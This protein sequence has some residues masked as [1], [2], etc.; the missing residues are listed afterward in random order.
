M[1]EG[2]KELKTKVA[3]LEKQ[4]A[5]TSKKL[6]QSQQ[7]YSLLN[8]IIA[9]MPG[10]IYWMDKEGRILGCNDE[11]AQN[12][13]FS[14]NHDLIG[15]TIHDFQPKE[16]ADQI[17]K[18]NNQIIRAGKSTLVE[19]EGVL[20]NG[21]ETIFLSHKAPLKNQDGKVTG[22]IGIS[23]DITSN[24]YNEH[25]LENIISLLPGNIFWKSR[26]G[27]FL[28]CNNNVAKILKLQYPSDI[29]GKTNYDLFDAAMADQATEADNVVMQN[30]RE[31]VL[32]ETGLNDK[33]ELTEYLTRKV[34]LLDKNNNVVGLLGVSLDISDRKKIEQELKRAKERAEV[35]NKAKTEFILN[36]EHDLRTPSSG[37]YGL[38][39]ILADTA[40]NKNL[41]EQLKLIASASGELLDIL[42]DILRFHQIESGNLP[43][44][45]KK[46]NPQHLI[47]KIIRLESAAAKEKNIS[48]VCDCSR[49]I[50]VE[51]IGDEYRTH[52]ILL[53]L[54]SNAIK[55]TH[56]GG[57]S[58]LVKELKIIKP[59]T[60]IL[61][62]TIKDTGIGIPKEKSNMIYEKFSK[63]TLSNTGHYKGLGLG[64]HIVKQFV[65]EL[66]GDIE[67]T[68]E[69][70]KGSVFT[71]TLPFK[72]PLLD[73][74][75]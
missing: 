47:E 53:N 59:R 27:K 16:K 7:E 20:A 36:M 9:S 39:K 40:S 50:P 30:N 28:G 33:G 22:V 56:R 11:Q 41:K 3:T 4:L 44:L 75:Q 45:D 2:V 60:I 64:L 12:V 29:I 69:V 72:L 62:F 58:V 57:V 67:V 15:K 31:Y 17:I 54:I 63:L 1:D 46:F 8:H 19:E 35:A 10:H 32:E 51:V 65:D 26:D 55:F 42:N 37:I 23:T 38:S 71:C 68:S 14:S 25:T 5:A 73:E 43:I 61:C 13:G 21:D 6:A 49:D 48:L 18:N 34:P 52:R 66:D 24:K 70:G 74:Q